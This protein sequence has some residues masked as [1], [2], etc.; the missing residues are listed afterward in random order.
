M[1]KTEEVLERLREEPGYGTPSDA[2]EEEEWEKQHIKSWPRQ[3]HVFGM[4]QNQIN[5]GA[6]ARIRAL[7]IQNRTLEIQ[8]QRLEE[9]LEALAIREKKILGRVAA[10][11]DTMQAEI[12][13]LRL[14][15]QLNSNAIDR[16]VKG[17][18]KS[19]EP[20]ESEPE[21]ASP[22]EI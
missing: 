22:E 19:E 2:Y 16:L 11:M 21:T 1:E 15:T 18:E 4:R 3:L 6:A 17:A 7:E 13:R 9:Q 8:N 20:E 12:N 5:R 14:S 10:E